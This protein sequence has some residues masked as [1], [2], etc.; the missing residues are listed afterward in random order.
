MTIDVKLPETKAKTVEKRLEEL[1]KQNIAL[2]VTYHG[3]EMV[4]LNQENSD[5]RLYPDGIECV[6]FQSRAHEREI[7]YLLFS[8]KRR[9]S[10]VY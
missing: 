10:F 4:K 9:M 8:D 5:V 2:Q 3:N 7:T 6:N 1:I